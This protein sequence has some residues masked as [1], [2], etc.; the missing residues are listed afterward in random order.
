[1]ASEGCWLKFLL[2]DN[3]IEHNVSEYCEYLH[4]FCTYLQS[5]M[6]LA[7]TVE[8]LLK[9]G[10]R[11]SCL[12]LKSKTI[13]NLDSVKVEQKNITVDKKHYVDSRFTLK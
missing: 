9:T 12:Y 1:L 11:T 2:S 4:V 3:F 7:Y 10:L 13:L 6:V 5:V 8:C